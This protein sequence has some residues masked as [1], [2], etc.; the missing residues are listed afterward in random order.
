VGFNDLASRHPELAKEFHPTRNGD[1]LP[2]QILA[3]QPKD[4]WWL[5][6]CGHEWE[7]RLTNRA[8]RDSGC[9]ECSTTGYKSSLPGLLYFI[10]NETLGSF[11][12]GITNPSAKNDRLKGFKNEGWTVHF[13][14]NDEDGRL[15]LRLETLLLS[16]IRKDLKLPIHLAKRSVKSMRGSSETFANGLVETVT[17]IKAIKLNYKILKA[18]SD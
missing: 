5:G 1:I 6:K 15:I 11:K 9:P 2:S 4:Y 7:A 12:I 13:T 14:I 8:S 3:G 17:V 10:E 16:W 18:K